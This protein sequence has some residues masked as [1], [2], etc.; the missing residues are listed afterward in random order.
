MHVVLGNFDL[1]HAVRVLEENLALNI[2]SYLKSWVAGAGAGKSGIRDDFEIWA[3]N[4]FY[5]H[6]HL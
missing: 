1:A 3:S 6:P 5:L 2:T 4:D